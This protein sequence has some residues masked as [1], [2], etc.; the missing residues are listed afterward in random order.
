[1]RSLLVV[2]LLSSLAC[3]PSTSSTVATNEPHESNSRPNSTADV[4]P[5]PEPKPDPV[6][7]PK[8][9]RAEPTPVDLPVCPAESEHPFYCDAHKQLVGS[10]MP[11]DHAK[12]PDDVEMI[13]EA[14]GGNTDQSRLWIGI[15]GNTLYIRHVT[16]GA[17]RR[18]MGLGFI[19]H[20]D[21]MTSDQQRAVQKQL[22]LPDSAPLLETTEAWAVY[23]KTEAGIAALTEIA[24]KAR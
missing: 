9:D 7:D 8:P 22:G 17:C 12:V 13:F 21:H 11:V 4:E 15:S 1:M 14:E 3:Q 10:W 23:A 24:K 20:L 19:G 6:E 16:C 5:E 2:V 18:V